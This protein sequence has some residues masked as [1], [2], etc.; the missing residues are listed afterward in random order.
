MDVQSGICY[1]QAI[2]HTLAKDIHIPLYF[3]ER[4]VQVRTFRRLKN[5]TP[6]VIAY[7]NEHSMNEILAH[8]TFACKSQIN[9]F[10]I[11]NTPAWR[12]PGSTIRFAVSSSVRSVVAQIEADRL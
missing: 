11:D 3:V 1:R 2:A 10:R 12:V 8:S 6:V 7:M 5:G 9:L 4:Y